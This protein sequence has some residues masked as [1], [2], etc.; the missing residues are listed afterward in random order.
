[1]LAEQCIKEK[2]SVAA[3]ILYDVATY[4]YYEKVS[5]TMR[6][7]IVSNILYLNL[8]VLFVFLKILYAIS[9]MFFRKHL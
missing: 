3:P 7:A 2:L 1:M 6:T 9:M 4:F 8:L 5:R